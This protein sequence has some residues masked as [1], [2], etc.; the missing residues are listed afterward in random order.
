ME[1]RTDLLQNES[2]VQKMK[3]LMADLPDGPTLVDFE[4]VISLSSVRGRTRLWREKDKLTGFAFVDDYNNL[5]F[6]ILPQYRTAWMEDEIIRWGIECVQKRNRESGQQNTLD[7]SFRLK[8]K[9]QIGMLMRHGFRK[10][11]VRTLHYERDLE[12]AIPECPLAEGYR[13]RKAAGEA[14][15]EELVA[16]HRAA[17]GTENM[18]VEWRLA[19]MRAPDY[20][21]ELDYVI[22]APNGEMAAFCICGFD[23]EDGSVGYTDPIGTHPRCQRQGLGK[24]IVTAG[25][26]A[27]KARGAKRVRL[28]TSSTNHGMRKLAESLGFVVASESI[29]FSRQVP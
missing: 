14:E 17:F 19:I 18:S 5:Q 10:E 3:E 9:W 25:M 23:S 28:G 16:L 22:V 15:V 11:A 8:D 20:E 24:A 12:M 26:E 1:M 4:E 6:E 29:W 27:L 21:P 13:L 7:A 2:D